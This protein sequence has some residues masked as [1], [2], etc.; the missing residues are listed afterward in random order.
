MLQYVH[1]DF[2]L[3]ILFQLFYIIYLSIYFSYI[4]ALNSIYLINFNYFIDLR[5]KV[6]NARLV[7]TSVVNTRQRHTY[8][9]VDD[10]ITTCN[11][12]SIPIKLD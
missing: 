2:I 12:T 11:E 4:I 9:L 10:C 1:A 7:N 5:H 3:F 6:M 8:C